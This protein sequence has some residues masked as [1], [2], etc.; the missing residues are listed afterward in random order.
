MYYAGANDVYKHIISTY[1]KL[2][3]EIP[4]YLCQKII[5]KIAHQHR[6]QGQYS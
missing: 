6:I 4:F 3:I 1:T 5:L 2:K